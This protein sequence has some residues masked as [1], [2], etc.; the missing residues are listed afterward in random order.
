MRS[1]TFFRDLA[2]AGQLLSWEKMGGG[3]RTLIWI[4]VSVDFYVANYFSGTYLPTYRIPPE[5]NGA[6]FMDCIADSRHFAFYIRWF[7]SC[8]LRERGRR[9]PLLVFQARVRVNNVVLLTGMYVRVLLH[10]R[11]LVK[12]FSAKLARIRSGIGMYQ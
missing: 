6:A 1:V 8:F 11:F 9:R 5:L 4:L 3:R 12:S 2:S 10:V 7:V